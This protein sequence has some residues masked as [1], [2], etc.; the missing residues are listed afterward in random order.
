[1]LC[2]ERLRHAVSRSNIEMVVQRETLEGVSSRVT[3]A[4]EIRTTGCGLRCADSTNPRTGLSS[5]RVKPKYTLNWVYN[6]KLY[7]QTLSTISV[8]AL[9]KLA[10]R[11]VL[12]NSHEDPTTIF[13]CSLLSFLV[14]LGCKCAESP[15]N[16]DDIMFVRSHY[17]HSFNYTDAISV[18]Y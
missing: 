10:A 1:M 8:Y 18:D 7:P 9:H 13:L 5:C 15:S 17:L 14:T 12:E 2:L 4:R 6:P 3:V 11:D 16:T